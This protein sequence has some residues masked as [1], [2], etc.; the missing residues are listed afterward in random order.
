VILRARAVSAA[1]V[2]IEGREPSIDLCGD[3]PASLVRGSS[4]TN[5][6]HAAPALL[7][8]E[9]QSDD[10]RCSLTSATPPVLTPLDKN[11]HIRSKVISAWLSLA[12]SV[13]ASGAGDGYD[14]F[15]VIAAYG[16]R[17]TARRQR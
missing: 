17:P 6:C 14:R 10:P 5:H 13:R 2:D 7:T 15:C 9:Y 4:A 16:R 3:Q 1:E 11:F 8:R 12:G